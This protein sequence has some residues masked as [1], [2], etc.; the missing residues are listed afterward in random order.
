MLAL[1]TVV[2][3]RGHVLTKASLLAG[4]LVCQNAEGQTRAARIV[5]VLE[6][7]DLAL[8]KTDPRGLTP[9]T[10]Q[11]GKS[12]AVGA[13]LATP[14]LED[15]SPLIGV[16]SVAPRWIDRVKRKVTQGRS[17]PARTAS[18]RREFQNQLGG[19]LSQR[20]TGFPSALQHDTVLRPEQCG[21]PLF[22]LNGKAVGINIARAGRAASYAI[23]ADELE[24]LL[25]HLLTDKRE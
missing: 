5:K 16:L 1:G 23:P 13:F 19:N 10:W 7:Y 15:R 25:R 24:A 2:N 20:R 8:L 17:N 3:N 22:D 11:R 21:G 18:A 9:V 4:E 12:P 6:K 14:S